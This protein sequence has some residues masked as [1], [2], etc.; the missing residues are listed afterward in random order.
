MQTRIALIV[1]ALFALLVIQSVA[2]DAPPSPAALPQC[3]AAALAQQQDT[4]AQLLN[5]DFEARPDQSLANLYRLGAVYQELA[6][7][8]GYEPSEQEI[9]SL[10]QL[11]L[12]LADLEQIIAA[13]AIGDDV[14]AIMLAL[15]DV[16]G[17]SFTGQLLY[18]GMEPGL[19]G[20]GLGCAGCHAG[21]AAPSTEGTWTRVTEVHLLLPQFADYSPERYLVESIVHPND[22]IAPGYEAN[23]MPENF[24]N[25]LDIQQLADLL[26]Y[27][28]SQDQF[29]EE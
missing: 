7:R 29:L 4:F 14:D 17:D 6:A 28:S 24:G 13:N 2:Q 16:S 27:L 9:N 15:E 26:A 12:S 1:L 22:Y 20:S 18:N 10:I 3:E 21:A 23:L 8:C 25:R 5:F 19:D 11:T